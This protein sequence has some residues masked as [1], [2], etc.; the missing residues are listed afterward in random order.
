MTKKFVSW[1]VNGIRAAIKK[2]FIESFEEL[3]PDIIGLQEIKLSEG[4]LDLELPGYYMYWNYAEKKGYSGTAVFT[5]EE[6]L[7]VNYG[8]GIEEHDKEGR[9]YYT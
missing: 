3:N 5:R 7:N 9:S 6:P 8:I 1:N 2:G 4:Q